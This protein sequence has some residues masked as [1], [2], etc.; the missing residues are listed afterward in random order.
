MRQVTADTRAALLDD[1]ET[2]RIDLLWYENSASAGADA[3]ER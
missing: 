3:A 2:V 1:R